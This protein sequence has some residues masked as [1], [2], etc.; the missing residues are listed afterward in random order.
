MLSKFVSAKQCLAT[1]VFA[2]GIGLSSHTLA[3]TPAWLNGDSQAIWQMSPGVYKQGDTW[4]AI[5]HAQANDTNVKLY[6][7]FTGWEGGAVAL[8][9]TPDGKFWWFK[10]TDSS[11]A[12]APQHGDEYRFQIERDGQIITVQDPAARWV[13]D[14]NLSTGMSKIY[15]SDHYQ[16]Q[17]NNWD[18]P[19]QHYLN[20]YQ[21]HPLRFTSRNSGSPFAQVTEELNNNGTNDYISDLGVTA[22]EFLPIS[23]FEGNFSWGYNPSFFYAIESS[24]GGPDALKALVDEAHKNGIAVILDLEYNHVAIGDNI[25][26]QVN[27]QTYLDGDTVWGGLINYDNDVAKHFFIENAKYLAKEFRIDGFRFDS[28]NTIHNVDSANVTV[29]GSGGGWQFLRELYGSVKAVDND[30][31]FTGEE[32]PDWWGLT[33]DDAGSSVAGS[34]HGP[35]DSQWVDT[36]YHDFKAVLKGDHLDRLFNVWG[37]FGDGWQDATVF[38]SSHDTVGNVDERIAKVARDGKGWEMNQISLAGTILARGT[39]MVFMG[40]EAGETTQFHIDWWDDRLDLNNYTTDTARKKIV[41][42]YKKLNEIRRNDEISLATGNSWVTHIHNDN[43][44]AAF[45]RDNGKY[46]VVM[47]FRGTTW[48][49]YDV[50][51]SGKYIELA[52]TSW[53]IYNLDNVTFASRGGEQS[54]EI[55]NVHI[56]AYGAVVLMRDDSAS[57]LPSVEFSCDNATTVMGQNV[58]AV[59]GIAELGNWDVNQAFALQPTA[60]P[61]WTARLDNLP[62]NTNFEWKCIKRDL[63]DPEWQAGNNNVVNAPTTGI[64]TSSG[65][66]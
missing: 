51:I 7:A 9:P 28:T 18:R 11:F 40:Q 12:N 35:M 42:W 43:G 64:V 61:T 15:L 31:W 5:F 54:Y 20:I 29:Q 49:D 62:A 45:V 34:N 33:S 58:Y 66:F 60:Y 55:T 50:G 39:P 36:F 16:W 38:A 63:G 24:F 21:L 19:Q 52:N 3:V 2:L 30:I 27:N 6:G 41:D 23:E 56:P 53:P 17:S 32:L 26:W 22:I 65:S 10:G 48:F 59:G 1:A 37:E 14:S 47:N 25:L 46:V 44:V 57:P 13:T 4:Y 8:T